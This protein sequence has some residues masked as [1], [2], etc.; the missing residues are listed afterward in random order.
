M[1]FRL[2]SSADPADCVFVVSSRINAEFRAALKAACPVPVHEIPNDPNHASDIWMQDSCEFGLL[3]GKPAVMLGLRGRHNEGLECGPLDRAVGD[4]LTQ[5][6]PQ[7]QQLRVGEP[8]P[9]RRWIDWF[10]NLECTP[11][12]GKYP[13]GRAIVGVQRGLGMHPSVLAFLEKQGLQW[14]PLEI[15]V[16]FLVIGHADEILNF[17]PGPNG[18]CAVIPDVKKAAAYLAGKDP[19]SKLWPGTRHEATV[20]SLLGHC[21]SPSGPEAEAALGKL[22]AQLKAELGLSDERILKIPQ[23]FFRGGTPWPNMVNALVAGGRYFATD[24]L[25]EGLRALVMEALAPS[26]VEVR[27]L[28]AWEPYSVRGGDIHCGTNA[29]RRPA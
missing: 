17:V 20:E 21:A 29:L 11:P 15:D 5:N 8:L 18:F 23:V 19:K 1:P 13:H 10:G 12:Y 2:F 28:P 14:P 9:D 26:S 16:S 4:W 22:E 25:D 24:P 27:F 3:D 6:M 7:V